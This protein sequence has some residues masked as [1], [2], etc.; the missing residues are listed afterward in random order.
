MIRYMFAVLFLF[1]LDAQAKYVAH[2]QIVVCTMGG[3]AKIYVDG[4]LVKSE[5]LCGTSDMLSYTSAYNLYIGKMQSS[6]TG[7]FDGSIDNV[8]IWDEAL[9]APEIT[10]LY[11]LGHG[12]ETIDFNDR[13]FLRQR[14]RYE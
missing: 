5:T 4:V 13:R 3:M 9:T 11:N 14:T 12:T 8:T 10:R 1:T 7:I 2:W 6:S